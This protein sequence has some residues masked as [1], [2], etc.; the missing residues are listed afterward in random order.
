M[1]PTWFNQLTPTFHQDLLLGAAGNYLG[2]IA[3]AATAQIIRSA[4]GGIIKK[5]KPTPRTQALNLAMARALHETI[6]AITDNPDKYEHLLG[7]FKEWIDREEV[8]LELSQVIDPR[9]DTE[10]D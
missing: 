6:N 3:G 7:I 10:I 2:G 8:A 5:Y 4:E 1:D 9:P